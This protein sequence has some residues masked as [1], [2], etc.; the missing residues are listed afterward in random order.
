MQKVQYTLENYPTDLHK[1]VTLL[2]HF[3][4]YMNENLYKASTYSFVDKNRIEDLD[5]L[6]KYLRT[7][8]A[9]IFRLSN[10]V[11][12]VN[13]FDHTKLMFSGDGN[14]VSFVDRNRLMKSYRLI[15]FIR[16]GNSDEINKLNYIKSILEQLTLRKQKKMQQ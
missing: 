10:K 9:V 13:F 2:K 7:K 8:R 12:Q 16:M 15:E 3:K 1:K 6:T 4:V 5:F 14:I 11:V